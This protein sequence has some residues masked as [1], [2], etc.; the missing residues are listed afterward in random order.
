MIYQARTAPVWNDIGVDDGE[1]AWGGKPGMGG[2]L[3]GCVGGAYPSMGAFRTAHEVSVDQSGMTKRTGKVTRLK[4][5]ISPLFV[6]P[7]FHLHHAREFVCYK[8]AFVPV[9]ESRDGQRVR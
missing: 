5:V 7:D 6:R 1:G 9:F 8:F 3:G 2:V 4:R